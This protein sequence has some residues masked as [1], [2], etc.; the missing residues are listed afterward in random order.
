MTEYNKLIRDKI[1]EII[2]KS[3]KKCK[4]SILDDVS[5]NICLLNKLIEESN[6]LQSAKT[7]EEIIEELADVYEV[8]EAFIQHNNIDNND[9]MKIKIKKGATKGLFNKKIF[10][11]YV[12]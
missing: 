2:K 12:E 5:F 4:T 9:I 7:K 11:E 6:E 10:L 8:L 1:P 3:G